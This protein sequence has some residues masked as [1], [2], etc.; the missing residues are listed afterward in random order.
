MNL[1]SRYRYSII[2]CARWEDR[3]VVEWL[4][5]YRAIGFDHIYLYC[6]DDDP[7]PLSRIVE[8][9]TKGDR[10]FVTFRFH[11]QQGQQ[12][13]MYLDFIQNDACHSE[14][15]GFFDLDEFLRIPTGSTVGEFLARFPEDVD[16]VLFNWVFFGPNGHKTPPDMPVLKAYTRRQAFLHQNTKFLM[17]SASV[18]SGSVDFD[19]GNHPF[20][21]RPNPLLREGSRIVNVLGEPAID[22]Y[23]G[24]PD[25]PLAFIN[26]DGRR[27]RIFET[28]LIHHYAFRSEQAFAERAARGTLGSFAGQGMW[29]ELAEGGGFDGFLAA[30][31]AVED[32]SLVGFNLLHTDGADSAVQAVR[33]PDG[34]GTESDSLLSRNRVAT[35]SSL[36][37]WSRGATLADDAAGALNGVIDGRAGFHTDLEYQPWWRVDLGASAQ[38]REIRIFNRLDQPD[39]AIRAANLAIDIG[40]SDHDLPERYRRESGDAFGGFDGKPLVIK[41]DPAVE[42]RV[43]RVRLLGTG[44][45]HLDQVQ[46]F[47]F[48]QTDATTGAVTEGKS[49]EEV[50]SIA[51]LSDRALLERFQ[52]IG[53]NCEFGSV[54]KSVGIGRLSLLQW[55]ESTPQKLI[56]AIASNLSV[57]TEREDIGVLEDRAEYFWY[58]PVYGLKSHSFI[59]TADMRPDVFVKTITAR[60]RFLVRKFLEDLEEGGN[61]FVYNFFGGNLENLDILSELSGI[62][63]RGTKN[64]LLAVGLPGEYCREQNTV[65]HWQPGLVLATKD[66]HTSFNNIPSIFRAGWLAICRDTLHLLRERD[67]AFWA[68]H[69]E[70]AL[71]AES[72]QRAVKFSPGNLCEGKSAT[73]SSLSDYSIGRTIAED[74]CGAINGRI[75]GQ[76][77]FHTDLEDSPWWQVDLGALFGV[78]AIRI[79][80]RV[81]VPEVMARSSHLA[82]EV[83][84]RGDDWVE[85]YRRED[86]APF[87]GVDGHPLIF[88]PLIP[89][90]G[91]FVRV[92]LLRRGYLHLDQVE[93]FGAVFPPGLFDTT[94]AEKML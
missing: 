15:F 34:L 55:T 28:A 67:P 46:V 60:N 89:V 66:P 87:G 19:R 38:I 79:Y 48:S 21:H 49:S 54:Q 13:E 42:G 17:R 91:R 51:R 80:N 86:D 6:N 30:M 77:K 88:T 82:I 72:V 23:D 44:Y 74:A 20:W 50:E 71:S 25:A 61:I 62:L 1:L 5:Y 59:R 24:F 56:S 57:F 37:Y 9:F 8:P 47:G 92:R 33:K 40:P 11:A 43:V 90:P 68:L 14:W 53:N 76:M 58:D 45:L 26:E 39:T 93:V 3:Y 65:F 41:F 84:L 83:G 31:N 75:D 16:A 2:A 73:Q 63:S 35:Q 18:A 29:K 70:R 81:D 4:S 85:I 7:G 36:S 22:Y 69:T 52:S 64:Y 78:T 32:C 12:R 27:E 10:P 94:R